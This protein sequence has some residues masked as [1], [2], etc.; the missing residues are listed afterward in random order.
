M[1]KHVYNCPH[2]KKNLYWCFHCQKPERVGKF[3][4]KRCQGIPSKTDRMAS[5]ARRIFSKLGSKN[6]REDSISGPSEMSKLASR[7]SNTT[8][9]SIPN[10]CPQNHDWSSKGGPSNWENQFISELPSTSVC[11]E[12]P[13]NWATTSHELPDTYIAEMTGTEVQ[14][15]TGIGENWGDNFYSESLED[16]DVS[17][18]HTVKGKGSSPRLSLDTSVPPANIQPTYVHQENSLDSPDWMEQTLSNTMISPMSTTEPCAGFDSYI[19]EVSPTDTIAS[20]ASF[21]ADS[22][23]SSASSAS[24]KYST[25]SFEETPSCGEK[26]GMKRSTDFRPISE[27]WAKDADFSVLVPRPQIFA[28]PSIQDKSEEVIRHD[29]VYSNHSADRCTVAPEKATFTSPLWSDATSLVHCFSEVLDAHLVHTKSALKD[30][31]RNSLTQELLAMS[32][33]SMVSIGLG[34]LAGFLEGRKPTAIIQVAAFVHIAYALAITMDH[35]DGKIHSNAW[36]QNSFLLTKGVGSE[37]QQQL[38]LQIAKA[39]WQPL[40][41]A[42]STSGEI[43]SR[44]ESGNLMFTD[45]KHFLDGETLLSPITWNTSNTTPSFREFTNSGLSSTF[46]V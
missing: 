14:T 8:D 18:S 1:L 42:N 24:W 37:R 30:L 33:S 6:H 16:W 45:C 15:H 46:R 10:K 25:A 23:Y 19:L 11:P 43:S 44:D 36:F 38:Y 31:P 26:T 4:C 41:D 32:K 29:S 9:S 22:G 13:A 7:M 35:D 3:Q 21:F 39:I 40:V 17:L 27:E 34:V 28:L 20:G 2:L 12:M 5:V